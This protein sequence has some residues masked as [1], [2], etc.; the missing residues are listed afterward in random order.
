MKIEYD[1]F[2]KLD[3]RV[4]YIK[5]CIDLQEADN[6]YKLI[7]DCGEDEPRQIITGMKKYY[8]PRELIGVKTLILM[9]LKSRRIMG[10]LSEG[11]LLAVDVDNEPILVKLDKNKRDLVPPGAK[12]R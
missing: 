6:L 10:E 3:I 4:G 12:I 5:E 11:M 7:V 1:D 9:N 2:S 8:T